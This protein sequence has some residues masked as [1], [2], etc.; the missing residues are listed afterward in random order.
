MAKKIKDL[1]TSVYISGDF[2]GTYTWKSGMSY[3]REGATTGVNIHFSVPGG[4]NDTFRDF[5]ISVP[6]GGIN[7]H[8][9]YREGR[10]HSNDVKLPSAEMAEW[11]EWWGINQIR[12]NAAAAMFWTNVQA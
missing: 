10:Y 8:I 6:Y 4:A 5:H 3:Y 2:S 9:W 12:C 1:K 7:A 11:K